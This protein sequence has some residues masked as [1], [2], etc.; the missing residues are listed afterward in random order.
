MQGAD[1]PGREIRALERATG[2]VETTHEDCNHHDRKW[3]QP[4]EGR[5]HDA[6][7]AV[8]RLPQTL[9]IQEVSNIADVARATQTGQRP[10]QS[11]H[12]DDLA[13]SSHTR[14]LGGRRSIADDLHLEAVPSRPI[15]HPA[16]HRCG[17]PHPESQGEVD[18]TDVGEGPPCRLIERSA[19]REDLSRTGQQADVGL[20][21]EDQVVGDVARDVVQHQRDDDLVGIEERLEG[22]DDPGPQSA[23]SGAG[24]DHERKRTESELLT[25]GEAD[26][27]GRDRSHDELTFTTD[28]EHAHSKRGRGGE[29]GEQQRRCRENRR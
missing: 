11:H 3:V 17:H 4:G 15:E 18:G 13:P 10:G 7:V 1:E 6:G 24:N 28:V 19:L 12:R 29:S 26:V 2:V 14:V 5:D 21:V 25:G 20:R 16:H 23:G 9:R 27:G 8:A 22:T